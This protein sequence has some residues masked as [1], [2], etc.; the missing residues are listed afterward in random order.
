M[1]AH[2]GYT[3][4]G[5]AALVILKKERSLNLKSLLVSSCCTTLSPSLGL[6]MWLDLWDHGEVWWWERRAELRHW[7]QMEPQVWLLVSAQPWV[8]RRSKQ[9]PSVS[10]PFSYL[11]S[12]LFWSFWTDP[13]WT[14]VLHPPPGMSHCTFAPRIA[15]VPQDSLL[16]CVL[17]SPKR[18]GSQKSFEAFKSQGFI[19]CENSISAFQQVPQAELGKCYWEVWT[20]LLDPPSSWPVLK[21]RSC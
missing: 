11:S 3:F 4:C 9:L 8:S 12:C 13:E 5:L 2:G 20:S 14:W 19:T 1:E 10:T 16:P 7:A 18:R 6:V 21:K 15:M 17:E